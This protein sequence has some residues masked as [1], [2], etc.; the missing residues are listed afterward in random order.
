MTNA[1]PQMPELPSGKQLLDS[2]FPILMFMFLNWLK[3]DYTEP[4]TLWT[5]RAIFL[6]SVIV[7]YGSYFVIYRR[8]E[9][10]KEELSQ[11]TVSFARPLSMS[12]LMAA[13]AEGRTDTHILDTSTFYDY[14]KSQ[15]KSLVKSGLT[16]LAITAF[17]QWKWQLTQI[18]ILN[19]VMTLRKFRDAPLYKLHVEGDRSVKRPF[20]NQSQNPFSSFLP[21][22][23]NPEKQAEELERRAAE[24]AKAAKKAAQQAVVA[25]QTGKRKK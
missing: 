1:Q 23:M 3:L 8:I 4:T 16:S 11:Q 22:S 21:D 18:L 19:A 24:N 7:Q 15:L 20:K 6:A 9:A 12:E 5:I 2:F 14:D 17:F 10:K 25:P 13:N